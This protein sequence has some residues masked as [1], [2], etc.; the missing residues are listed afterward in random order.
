MNIVVPKKQPDPS[1]GRKQIEAVLYHKALA[2]YMFVMS[3]SE[4]RVAELP[5]QLLGSKDYKRL[6]QALCEPR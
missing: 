2:N 3:H 6:K 1:K 5:W 4:R